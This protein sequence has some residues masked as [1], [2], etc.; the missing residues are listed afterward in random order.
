MRTNTVSNRF[1]YEFAEEN[2]LD[3]MFVNDAKGEIVNSRNNPIVQGT[4]GILTASF[5]FTFLACF[6]GYLIYWTLSIKS[7]ALQFGVFHAMGMT[8]KNLLRML[9]YEQIF[10]SFSAI[11]IGVLV[12]VI[13]ARLFVPLIQVA[14]SPALL[15]IPLMIVTEVRD[16][17]N[18]FS[19]IGVMF[20]ICLFILGT[21]IS[22]LKIAQALKLG[23]D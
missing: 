9:F 12:G 5:I 18:I 7:R 10:I 3:L 21:L 20:V 1:F 23:E 19:V 16:Y 6:T 8:K 13:A 11:G 4:N 22:K 15:P 2:F 14:Y 17:I